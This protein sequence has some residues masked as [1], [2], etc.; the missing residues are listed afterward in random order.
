MSFLPQVH[1]VND[2][3]IWI[4]RIDALKKYFHVNKNGGLPSWKN[5]EI[6]ELPRK[7]Y[8]QQNMYLDKIQDSVQMGWLLKVATSSFPG[9]S[10]WRRRW[11]WIDMKK[12]KL[13]YLKNSSRVPIDLC[14]LTITT[15]RRCRTKPHSFELLCPTFNKGEPYLLQAE[16]SISMEQ[17]I[18]G[19]NKATEILLGKRSLDPDEEHSKDAEKEEDEMSKIVDKILTLNAHQCADCSKNNAD[20]ASINLGIVLCIQCAGVHRR[21]GVQTSQ[22]S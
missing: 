22:V 15:A 10:R 21:L 3:G 1:S 4:D 11:F 14:D 13:R 20:W 17:W 8:V 18:Q 7:E 9:R 5:R 12:G 19:L 6:Y 16:T 2:D